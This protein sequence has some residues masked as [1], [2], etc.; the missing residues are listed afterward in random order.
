MENPSV[1]AKLQKEVDEL[2]EKGPIKGTTIG[3]SSATHKWWNRR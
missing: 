3:P 2:N 1:Y